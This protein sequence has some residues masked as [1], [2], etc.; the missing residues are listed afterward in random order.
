MKGERT[1]KL[2]R[3]PEAVRYFFLA[4]SN[5]GSIHTGVSHGG[6]NYVFK[7]HGVEALYLA[8]LFTEKI[9]SVGEPAKDFL[10]RW[11]AH[12]NNPEWNY[13][14]ELEENISVPIFNG[15]RTINGERKCK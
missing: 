14:K 1:D 10:A 12:Y 6:L 9:I 5:S 13:V 11:R 2:R 8:D 7:N 15:R 4:V 3:R